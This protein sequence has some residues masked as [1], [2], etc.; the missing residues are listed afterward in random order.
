MALNEHPDELMA[1]FQQTYGLDL[2]AL[3][4]EAEDTCPRVLRAAALAYQLPRTS[5]TWVAMDPT[6]GNQTV[7]YLLRQMEHNQ[8][9]W[10]WAH[11]KDAKSGAN[12][13][14]PLPLPGE[15]ERTRDLEQ[16]ELRKAA[17]IAALMGL[18]I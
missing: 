18:N 10:A 9:M 3:G 8:R 12:E 13:P 5:R 17:D 7:E 14:D 1:D 4:V 15:E 6:N 2:W 16:Q 11:S